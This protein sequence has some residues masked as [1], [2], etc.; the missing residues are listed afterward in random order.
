MKYGTNFRSTRRK[1]VG[2]SENCIHFL[3]HTNVR[4]FETRN[5]TTYLSG[6]VVYRGCTQDFP[7]WEET[8]SKDPTCKEIRRHF[9]CFCQ[10]DRCNTHDMTS[11]ISRSDRETKRLYIGGMCFSDVYHS[12][13]SN[14]VTWG[15]NTL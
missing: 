1:I 7:L 9:L 3:S 8:F 2:Q 6:N 4:N 14:K 5:R 15:M 13:L 10:G 11:Y 12:Q